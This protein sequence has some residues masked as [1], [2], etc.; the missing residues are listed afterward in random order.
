M[1]RLIAA[2][3]AQADLDE[4]LAYLQGEAGKSVALRYGERFRAGFR[5]LVDFPETG[6]RRP[7]LHADMRIWVIAPYVIFYRFTGDDDT[8]R[9]VRI[10]HGRRNVTERLFGQ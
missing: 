9:L 5:H 2:R 10:L 4:I 8:I 3:E 7:Q 6:A 1:A